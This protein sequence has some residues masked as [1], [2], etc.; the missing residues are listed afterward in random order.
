MKLARKEISKV[1]PYTPGKP[2]EE[3]KREMGLKEVIKL[4]SN[5][6][7][8][9]PAPAAR[10]AAKKALLTIN[11]YPDGGCFYLKK[12]LAGHLRVRPENIIVGNGSDEIIILALRAFLKRGEEV[13][14]ARPTF[15]IYELASQIAGAR[16]K[17]APLKDFRY[18]I[19]RMARL[20]SGKTRLIFIANPDNPTGTYVTKKEIDFLVSRA[21]KNTIIY[22]DEAYFEF[23]KN[24][25]NF[26]DTMKYIKNKNIIITRSF[27]KIYSLA[28]LRVGYG[29]AKS[30]IIECLNRVREPFNVNS[31]AQAAAQASL[32]DRRY[33][34]K[35]IKFV[36]K[37]KSF[38]YK[39]LDSLGLKYIPSVTNFVLINTGRDSKK[40]YRKL[41]KRGIII[42]EM[43]PWKLTNFIR[44]TV[45]TMKENRKFIKALKEV[46]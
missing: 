35:T 26:P 28:G 40:V 16:I 2:I 45:G 37:A 20:I 34:E 1:K 44:V 24:I 13:I 10:R 46:L 36:E 39:E 33:I 5:E 12:A 41:L 11:R 7:A 18:D 27:S 4:A 30:E 21:P 9:P 3:V 43:S 32:N 29:I 6:N 31:V 22:F 42:R 23:A 25:K 15:L 38:L 14:I 19:P 17:F 8:L